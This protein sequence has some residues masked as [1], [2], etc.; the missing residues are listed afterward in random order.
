MSLLC[1]TA[2]AAIASANVRVTK[3]SWTYPNAPEN[4]TTVEYEYT[5]DGYISKSTMSVGDPNP[6]VCSTMLI[7]Y[8]DFNSASSLWGRYKNKYVQ[9]SLEWYGITYRDFDELNRVAKEYIFG[10]ENLNNVTIY[11]FRYDGGKAYVSDTENWSCSVTQSPFSFTLGELKDKSSYVWCEGKQSYVVSYTSSTRET[12]VTSDMVETTEWEDETRST[13]RSK[14][15]EYYAGGKLVAEKHAWPETDYS[16]QEKYLE[17]SGSK[18]EV[19]VDSK[20]GVT[21]TI[22]YNVNRK[23]GEFEYSTKVVETEGLGKP[24]HDSY[25]YTYRWDNKE[26]VWVLNNNQWSS[27]RYQW[28]AN[29]R[30]LESYNAG[31]GSLLN[32]TIYDADLNPIGVM[33]WVTESLYYV[34]DVDKMSGVETLTYYNS[35]NAYVR[36]IRMDFNTYYFYPIVRELRGSDWVA[37]TQPFIIKNYNHYSHYH[38][39]CPYTEMGWD[40]KSDRPSYEE[41]FNYDKDNKRYS[42]GQRNYDDTG[43]FRVDLNVVTNKYETKEVCKISWIDDHTIAQTYTTGGTY[44]TPDYKEYETDRKLLH[45][46]YYDKDTGTQLYSATESPLA[47]SYADEQGRAVESKINYDRAS[48]VLTGTMKV[49]DEEK[50]DEGKVVKSDII[51]YILDVSDMSWK[52][53]NKVSEY[54]TVKPEWKHYQVPEGF[55]IYSDFRPSFNAVVDNFT[56]FYPETS[57]DKPSLERNSVTYTY[58]TATGELVNTTSHTVE[59]TIEPNVNERRVIDVDNGEKHVEFE[60]YEMNAAGNLTAVLRHDLTDGHHYYY[61]KNNHLV[62]AEIDG[63]NTGEYNSGATRAENTS[64]VYDVT[65]LDESSEI[66]NSGV[67]QLNASDDSGIRVEGRQVY[68]AHG[69]SL[70]VYTIEGMMIGDGI[71]SSVSLPSSGVYIVCT[72]NA[73]H[74]IAVK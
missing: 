1:L 11:T 26:G 38:S 39:T 19:N 15:V 49:E 44:D 48:D 12:I 30:I 35:S 57:I 29:K 73:S 65:Y 37:P 3:E 34:K 50:N 69:R 58:D 55:R 51:N 60:R 20:T 6:E 67:E 71:S 5:K 36:K 4:N 53:A 40:V 28:I 63:G 33:N 61:N 52:L 8:Y 16:T 64:A 24:G 56:Y 54:Y 22:Q 31:D 46:Y 17:W 74:K 70:K 27:V 47:V 13:I 45:R 32:Q 23:T 25:K 59:Y 9:P 66:D 42:L 43:Y 62:R 18:T 7:E 68:S 10:G 14:K 41:D 21:E 72:A 2:I